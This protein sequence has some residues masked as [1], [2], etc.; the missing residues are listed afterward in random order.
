ML[1]GRMRVSATTTSP[2]ESGADTLAIGVFDGETV[3]HDVKGGALQRLID[4]G[5][6]RTAF[7]HVAVAHAGDRR[8]LV[9]GLGPRSAF[10]AERAR[11]AAAVALGRAQEL[12]TRA[13]CWEV[14]HHVDDAIAG[15]FVEG[16]VLAAYRFDRYKKPAGDERAVAEL[17]VSAHHDVA[18][19]VEAAAVL[20]EAANAARDLQNTP[21][22]DMTPVALAE[23]ARGLDG[24]SVEVH[25]RDFLAEQR[26]G[27]FA[28]VAHGSDTDPALI[29]MRYDGAGAN[30]RAG[31]VLGLVGKGVT[32]DTG[33]I[34]IKPAAKMHE[35]KFD[36]SGGAAVVAAVGAIARL[37]LP[38]RVIGVVGATENMPSGHSMRPGDIVTA[39][40]GTT[41]EINN[42]DA[43]GRLV[44]A[45][46]ITHAIGLGAER[47]VD[48][49]TL[50]GGIV[51]ALGSAFAGV[52]SNDDAW[53]ATVEAAGAHTGE[54]VWRLPLDPLY[55]DAIKGHYADIVNAT[56][57]RKAHPIT[58]AAFLA[59]FAG[60]VPWAHVD[61]AGT[62][63]DLGLAYAAKGGSGF[64][65]RLL[66][67]VARS[68]AAE[69]S[70]SDA[71]A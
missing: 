15:G 5:E 33:G 23:A 62:M 56:A 57:D 31:P 1:A 61:M 54:R 67:E 4:S 16:T 59:R 70:R 2:A 11:I 60:D 46:C 55:D 40:N 65:V 52:M 48:I 13:L 22:N 43:E 26:M 58:A 64:G 39:S 66:V 69:A 21:A 30:G 50:T 34:S 44:L 10:D 47:L 8:W 29:V 53:C 36:M 20:A 71:A 51:T 45:D 49:A 68:V 19:P 41:I 3:A 37:G 35:M 14:P 17:I 42:T 32:F 9:V 6:G 12:G 27:A 63:N 18:A 38:V 28:A 7:R 24:V 25:G